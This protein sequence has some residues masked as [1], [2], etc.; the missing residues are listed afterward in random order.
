[1]T[2]FLQTIKAAELNQSK[3]VKIPI[4][5][6]RFL[7]ITLSEMLHKINQDYESMFSLIKNNIKQDDITIKMDGGNFDGD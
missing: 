1:M 3:D 6:A 5:Q 4:A 7:T 2:Q